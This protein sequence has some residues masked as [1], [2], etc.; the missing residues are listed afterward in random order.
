[1]PSTVIKNMSEALSTGGAEEALLQL[2]EFSESNAIRL[3]QELAKSLEPNGNG[4]T[5]AYGRSGESKQNEDGNKNKHQYYPIEV[6]PCLLQ[7]KASAKSKYQKEENPLQTAK[8]CTESIL[9]SLGKVASGGSQASS[10]LRKLETTRRQTDSKAKDLNAAVQLRQLASFGADA[11]GARRYTDA[12]RAVNDYRRIQP[13]ERGMIIAGP[14]SAR[15]YERT[16]DV[17]QRTVLEHYENAVAERDIKGLSELTP[18]LGMLDLANKGV[19]LYLR[20]SQT[21]LTEIM[22]AGL[23]DDEV[24]ESKQNAQ[25][26][27]E[28]AGMR[29][30]RA[31]QR[32]RE[33]QG[34]VTVCTKLAKIFN[35]AVTHL[36]HHLPMVAFSLGDADGDAAL[37]QLVHIEVEKRATEI[38]KD[39]IQSSNLGTLRSRAATVANQLEERCLSG[40]VLDEGL[41]GEESGFLGIA[42]GASQVDK[43][44]ALETMDDCGFKMELGTF[45]RMNSRLDEIAL[46]M[47]HAESYERFI[48]HAVDEVNKARDLRRTQKQDERKKQWMAQLEN[49]EKDATLEEAEKFDETEREV[50]ASQRVQDVLPPQTQLNE[51]IAEVGGYLS[52]FERAFFLGNLQRAFFNVSLPDDSNYSPLTTLDANRRRNSAGCVALQTSLV[53]ECLYAAQQ[54]TLRAFATGHNGIASAAANVCSDMLGRVLLESLSHRAEAGSS[55]LKPGDGLLSGQGGLGQAALS[56][57]STAQKGLGRKTRLG[58]DVKEEELAAMKQEEINAGIARSCASLNDLEV[59][60]DYTRRLER[61]LTQEMESTFPASRQETVQ[62]RT[63]ITSLS[64]VTE[65]YKNASKEAADHLVAILMPRIRSIVNECVGQDSTTSTSFMTSGTVTMSTVKMNYNLNDNAYEMAQI[66]E[67]YMSRL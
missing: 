63:C 50:Q 10:D 52:G 17:L 42:G 15:A 23:K 55:L 28:N 62:L 32:R 37:V 59:A 49:E 30:S 4:N 1:M 34:A 8:A 21:N 47:Q 5:S 51:I 40:E 44:A 46:L 54:S 20:Y 26:A 61:K 57:M 27:E 6:P 64:G 66:S 3:A 16:R 9:A 38:I 18:L 56:V 11:L 43:A 36:R 7:S 67:G 45:V 31:E 19:G 35:A 2:S 39:Y 33:Q 41:F 22:N 58:A 13:S 24:G 60:V 12:A 25:Q 29:I 14:H 53:E 65:L 48:R